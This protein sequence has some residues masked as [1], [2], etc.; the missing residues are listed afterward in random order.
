MNIRERITLLAFWVVIT[1]NLC[2]ADAI[3]DFTASRA[4]NAPQAAILITDLKTG[5][6][7]VSHNAD[8][9]LIPASIMKSVTTATLLEKTGASYKYTTPVFLT[10]ELADRVLQGDIIVEASGDPSL[11]SR[12][13]PSSENFVEEIVK[14]VKSLG[15]DTIKG[16]IVIDDSKFPG[17]SIN[18]TW[19]PG[20]LPHAYGTGTHGFNFEDNASGKKSVSDPSAIFRTRLKSALERNGIIWIALH[21]DHLS[22]RHP[23]G[24]HRSATIDEIMRSCMMRSD[25]QYAEG[26]LR[27]VGLLYGN[28]G[29]TKQGAKSMTDFWNHRKADMS[30]VTIVDGSGLSRSNRVTANFMTDV[31]KRMA[32]N[33]YYASFFPLAGQEGTLRKFLAGTPLEG[34]IALKTG[35]MNGIQ[36]YAGYKLDDD[37][38]PTHTVVVIMNEMGDRAAARK[39]VERLLLRTFDPEYID[40]TT[41]DNDTE[42]Q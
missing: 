16:D 11:N 4:I 34:Y 39:E 8:K 21:H 25:N 1:I 41:P 27:T 9:S 30:G 23:L 17:P 19:A 2:L 32:P 40:N 12:H 13:L 22:R 35:S 6:Q 38:S 33:P 5:K 36:C 18:P 29:S 28:S 15:I 24:E 42:N 26:L 31:L 20:D 3:G 10:G 7:I 14:A 37:Y